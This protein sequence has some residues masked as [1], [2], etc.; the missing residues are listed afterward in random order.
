MNH[1]PTRP[2]NG[3]QRLPSVE[4]AA[5]NWNPYTADGFDGG[6]RWIPQNRRT[7][8]TDSHKSPAPRES[9]TVVT[10]VSP[11]KPFPVETL[12]KGVGG[13][14]SEA[15]AAIGCDASFIA[16]PLLCCLARAIG[17]TRSIRLKRTW[18]ELAILWA[19]IVGK[20]GTHKTPAMQA[21]TQFLQARQSK[22]IAENVSAR[23]EYEVAT[24]LYE[25]NHQEWKKGKTNEPPPVE[26]QEPHCTR[27]MT[28]DATIEALAGL[29]AVQF[30]GLLVV[31]DELSGWLGGIA[32]YKGGKGSDLGHWLAA[33][34]G[35]P[36]TV[37][38]K[39]GAVKMIH[40]PRAAVSL[41]GGIQPGVLRG[42]IAKEHMQDG[43]CARLLMAMPEARPVVW[44][45]E[46]VDWSVESVLSGIFDQLLTLEP[47]VDAE[48]NHEPI[49]ID[50]T[51][52]AKDLWVEYFNRHRGESAGLEDDLAAAWSK[53]EAYTARFA[54]I[55]QLCSWAAGDASPDEIDQDSMDAAIRLS[56]WFGGEAKRIYGLFV[57]SNEEREAREL[58]ELIQRKGGSITARDLARASRKYRAS[59][60]AE[61]A[62]DHLTE[63]GMGKWHVT[64][65]STKQKCEFVLHSA[66]AVTVSDSTQSL[67]T[68][69]S[70]TAKGQNR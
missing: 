18:C 24:A 2:I 19:A 20:S 5:S 25:R 59:M 49:A 32:E 29:L 27:Y 14:V 23:E 69:E 67:E 8:V 15:S 50:M 43:L 6:D 58:C 37:D 1:L 21:A 9:E 3:E 70:V 22:A 63:M 46:S 68:G 48:G 4:E 41:V 66:T 28:S 57:E 11:Y 39:T 12:P 65:T 10:T 64:P 62:L 40:V 34:S 55:F 60:A 54:L 16:L 47:G 44:S 51:P 7:A 36:L 52:E 45:D 56:D 31:R 38:R 30:D 17:N 33:W 35:A 13:Y 42:S 26:P 61:D 53:L